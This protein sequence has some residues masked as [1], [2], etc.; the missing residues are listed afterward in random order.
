MN[1]PSAQPD[2]PDGLPQLSMTVEDVFHIK[3][4]GTVVVGPLTG[5]GLLSAG[6]FLECDGQRWPVDAVQ[7]G[8]QV[9]LTVTPGTTVG[10]LMKRGPEASV[11]RGRTVRFAPNPAPADGRGAGRLMRRLGGRPG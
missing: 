3:G 6:Y 9:V 7:P 10:V 1:F 4:R 11:L 2:D 5:D 8:R